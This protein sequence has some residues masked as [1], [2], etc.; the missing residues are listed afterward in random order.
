MTGVDKQINKFF[1]ELVSTL[2]S[3]IEQKDHYMRG[4]AERVAATCAAF[5]RTLKLSQQAETDKIY[6]AGLLYDIGMVYIPRE[7]TLTR[8]TLSE[9]EMTIVR[10]HPVIAEQIL[11]NLTILR[12]ILPM[13]RHHHEAFDGT[14]YPDGLKGNAIP[15]G[16][17][18]LGIVDSFDAMT[19]DRPHRKAL[20]SEAAIAALAEKAG[21]QYDRMLLNQFIRYLQLEESIERNRAP[22]EGDAKDAKSIIDNVVEAMKSGKI[23]LPVLPQ[24]VQDVEAVLKNPNATSEHLAKVIERDAV[25]S[26][27]LISVANSPYYRG[28][29]QITSVRTAISRLGHSE[30]Q[31][32]VA[33]IANKSLFET[34]HVRFKQLMEKLW[35]HSLACAYAAAAI[36]RKR[37]LQD[38]ETYFFVGI[39]H[40]IGKVVLIKSL[41]EKMPKKPSLNTDTIQADI[42]AHHTS[43]SRIMLKR[44]N[45]P[46]EIVNAV[47]RQESA[48]LPDD[49][50]LMLLVLRLANRLAESGGF[51][52][53]ENEQ[54][55]DIADH[56][57]LEPLAI[58]A[59]DALAIGK[60]VA[61][62]MDGASTHF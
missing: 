29:E 60:E 49:A 33:A 3:V 44:W 59:D 8:G 37:G 48:E 2:V 35:A 18:I 56:D 52:I 17:R 28:L 11:G 42:G 21:Q 24:I 1:T 7:I 22:A 62:V 15:L 34:K 26:I 43:V 10:Q 40:D 19:S 39:A 16:A 14:G 30:T 50:N 31:N 47:T 54:T 46:A 25:I 12:G 45:Y 5:S 23:D 36:A 32:L 55:A 6:F 13:I 57:C 27:R 9:D 38:V 4:H 41:A 58:S 51:G 53:F 61:A 20:T